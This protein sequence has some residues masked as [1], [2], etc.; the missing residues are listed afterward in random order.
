MR[1]LRERLDAHKSICPK[2]R[3]SCPYNKSGCDAVILREDRQKHLQEYMEQHGSIA[4]D[5]V[6]ALRNDLADANKRILAASKRTLDANNALESKR[7]PP[8][9]FK[10]NRYS[11][12]RAFPSWWKGPYFYTHEGGYKMVLSVRTRYREEE[13]MSVCIHL[14]K[15]PNDDKLVWPF[16][17]S[18]KIEI[19]NQRHDYGHHSSTIR[20]SERNDDGEASKPSRGKPI[21]KRLKLIS[22]TDLERE[23]TSCVYVKNDQIFFRISE[24]SAAA[25]CKPWLICSP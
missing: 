22:F 17:G 11:L 14:V 20:W 16:T 7:V 5:T 8:V 24:V 15:G 9:T 10:I 25:Q 12:L 18:V 23:S 19:L 3:I 4:N 1:V 13:N 6:S 21:S 2:E